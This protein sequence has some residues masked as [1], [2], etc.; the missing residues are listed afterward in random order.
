MNLHEFIALEIALFG[1]S[2]VC[3][4][5]EG[6]IMNLVAAI[7]REI[8]RVTEMV[9]EAR[10]IERHSGPRVNMRFYILQCE[11]VRE[12]AHQVMADHGDIERCMAVYEKLKAIN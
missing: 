6:E 4:N 5:G 1:N 8:Q 11:A 2:V 7:T 10:Q 9:E 3:I 12:E